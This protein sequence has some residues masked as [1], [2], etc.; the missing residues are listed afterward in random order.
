M[1]VKN[2]YELGKALWEKEEL[3]ET[4]DP[5]LV[6]FI[7]KTCKLPPKAPSE[8]MNCCLAESLDGDQILEIIRI[9]A[10]TTVTLVVVI[11][12]LLLAKH[13]IDRDYDVE[14]TYDPTTGRP[15]GISLRKK[16]PI[17]VDKSGMML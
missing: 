6:S 14:V 17:K 16:P 1:I 10:V 5:D 3:I 11:G 15:T 13:A 7:V 2:H 4:T 9:C 12:T 8:C